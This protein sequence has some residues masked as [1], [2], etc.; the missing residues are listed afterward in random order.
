MNVDGLEYICASSDAILVMESKE[1]MA[2]SAFIKTCKEFPEY[3][4]MCCH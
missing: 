1:M 3:I 2:R 4:C